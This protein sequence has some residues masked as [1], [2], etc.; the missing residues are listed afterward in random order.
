MTAINTIVFPDAA[1]MLTDAA[2]SLDGRIISIRSKPI[3]Y[4]Q[5]PAVAAVTGKSGHPG[6]IVQTYG[7]HGAHDF[8][9]MIAGLN[10]N[11]A[12]GIEQHADEG[13]PLSDA[14]DIHVIGLSAGQFQSWRYSWSPEDGGSLVN[15]GRLSFQPWEPEFTPV[16]ERS[17]LSPDLIVKQPP[18]VAVPSMAHV[19][20]H[21]RD[22]FGP[23]AG[24]IGGYQ[25]ATVITRDRS[26]RT[27][28][29]MAWDDVV[30]TE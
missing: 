25:Q 1:V 20:A 8:D 22:Y 12:F 15:S 5:L 29:V 4:P 14:F 18:D 19:M 16:L 6:W 24:V 10:D 9:S 21:Q 23:R 17:G 3:Y 30:A 13:E 26:I 2:V 27:N 28:V 7:D 11:M